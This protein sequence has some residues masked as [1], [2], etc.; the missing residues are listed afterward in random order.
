MNAT[1][2]KIHPVRPGTGGQLYQRVEFRTHLGDWAKCDLC[3]TNANYARWKPLLQVGNLLG[4]LTL[5]N[6]KTINADDHP[7]LVEAPGKQ[8]DLL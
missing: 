7:Y 6:D 4:G 2:T 8:L 5:F 3:P 1:I